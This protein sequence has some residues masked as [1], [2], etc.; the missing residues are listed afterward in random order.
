VYAKGRAI[1][2]DEQRRI[3]GDA[4]ALAR[5]AAPSGVAVFDLDSTLL[6]NRPR[7]A[8]ILREFGLERAQPALA[9]CAAEH[10]TSWS[11]ADAMRAA[12]CDE[13]DVA[14]LADDAKAW[15]RAR[16]FTSDY[17]AH[18]DPMPGAADFL[19]AVRAAGIRIAYVTGRHTEMRDGSI[20]SFRRAGFPLPDDDSVHLLLK[21]TFEM[22]DD[23]WKRQAYAR[24]DQIGPV[25]LAFDNEPSHINGYAERFTAA[26]AV[27]LATDDSGRDIPVRPGIPSI[28]D[29]V[30]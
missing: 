15:W 5:A 25:A 14:A 13:R 29:F 21:P 20:A 6:D 4:L 1:S 30:R 27:H 17:C 3:L 18:D 10:W 24:L 9:A 7:Q 19:A 16:F 12:G 28:A 22:P 26:L 2:R 8:L 23:D 11:I